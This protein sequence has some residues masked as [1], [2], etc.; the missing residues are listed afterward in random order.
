MSPLFPFGFGL[1][2]TEFALTAGDVQVEKTVVSLPVTVTNTG[3]LAGKEVVQLYASAPQGDIAKPFQSLAAFV[4]TKELYPGESETVNLAFD[5]RDM[6]SYCETCAAWVLDQG[7]YILRVGTSSRGTVIPAVLRLDE[8]VKLRQVKNLLG[9]PDFED[10]VLDR[11]V[12]ENL[13]GV[14]VVNIL[15]SFFETEFCTYQVDRTVD[16]FV[17]ALSDGDAAHLCLGAFLPNTSG[18]VLGNSAI[19]VAGAAGETTNYLADKLGGK[20]LTMADG[21]AGLRLSRQYAVTEQGVAPAIE[22]LPDGLDELM[23]E[24][25]NAAIRMAYDS[26]PK[27]AIREQYTTANDH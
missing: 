25:L 17:A 6:A 23:G 5:L 1:S 4:K 20:Y 15:A 14:P 18:G 2:Y 21:P 9:K 16:P 13:T 19:H 22:K 27:D 3:S 7:D 11:A 8:S 12:E 24:E 26:I 10:A